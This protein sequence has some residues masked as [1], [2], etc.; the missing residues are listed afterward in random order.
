REYPERAP[1]PSGGRALRAH[2]RRVRRLD[3]GA[4][5]TRRRVASYWRRCA[6]LARRR[7]HRP[8]F[9]EETRIAVRRF[10]ARPDAPLRR[11]PRSVWQLSTASPRER[12]L[13][14]LAGTSG[15]FVG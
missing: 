6:G 3:S 5:T 7:D 14:V 13:R 1:G 4:R 15:G 2:G 8:R 12:I 9:A 10:A 11:R